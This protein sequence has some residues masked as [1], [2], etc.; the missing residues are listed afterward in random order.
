M[1][2]FLEEI[3]ENL[4]ER[5]SN[6]LGDVTIVFPNKRAGLFFNKA[7][8]ER[9]K[10]PLWSPEIQS[11]EEFIYSL[12]GKKPADRLTLILILYKAYQKTTGASETFDRFYFWGE[13]MLNDFNDIDR[14]LVDPGNIFPVI[15]NLKEIDATFPF[16]TDEQKKF[17]GNFWGSI[18]GEPADHKEGFLRFWRMLPQIYKTY[19]EMLDEKG[20]CYPGEI[21][22]Q[23][24]NRIK[25]D[26]LRWEG[27][28][29]VFVGFNAL[30]AAEELIIKWFISNE[31]AMIFWDTDSWYL[32]NAW[33]EAGTFHRDYLKDKVLGNTFPK[34]LP[35]SLA[36][37][38][39]SIEIVS[40][41]SA[42]S[43]AQWTAH[44]IRELKDKGM[45]EHPE[46]T[47][48]VLPDE[49]MI[50]TLLF[51]LPP[52]AGSVNITVAYPVKIV[53]LFSFFELVLEL[54]ENERSSSNGTWYSHVQALPLLSHPVVMEQMGET[55][56]AIASE[57]RDL[58][59]IYIP[60]GKL[61]AGGLLSEIFK[62]V[63]NPGGIM[64]YLTELL[65]STVTPELP[66]GY[67]HEFHYYFFKLFNRINV[68]FS[69]EN[70]E[71]TFT[72]LKKLFRQFS[73][74]ERIS[75]SGEPLQGL[76][77]MGILETRNLD[78]DNVII[79]DANEGVLPG[80]A[81]H[82]SFIPYNVRRAFR[83]PN[84]EHDGSILAYLFYRLLQRSENVWIVYNTEEAGQSKGEPSRFIQQL[85]FD[86]G[87]KIKERVLVQHLGVRTEPE[88]EIK[89]SPEVNN[90]LRR[91]LSAPG[92]EEKHL[93]PSAI[94]TWLDCPVSFYF[95]YILGAR[96]LQEVNP[97]FDSLLFG[98]ILHKAMEELYSPYVGENEGWITPE[99]IAR[100]R[101]RTGESVRQ[102]F[103]VHF[104]LRDSR[105]FHF[106]GRNILGRELII[107]MINRILAIDEKLVPFRILG[108]EVPINYQVPVTL[109]DGNYRLN[110]RGIIDR[111][112]EKDGQVRIIDYKSG[113]DSGRFESVDALFGVNDK[114]RNKAVFQTLFYSLVLAEQGTYP[115]PVIPCLYNVREIF[116]EDFNPVIRIGAGGGIKQTDSQQ[117]ASEILPAF[118][119]NLNSLLQEI[120]DPDIPFRHREE[121]SPCNICARAGFPI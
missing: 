20:Y 104:G 52:E 116:N 55:A 46:K 6:D 21:Y 98:N 110:V 70:T 86:P 35:S 57:I 71:I 54:H 56:N 34:R 111:I 92:N 62:P 30:N 32:D 27:K 65:V 75:F 74:M 108:T 95:K 103:T 99:I 51:A 73:R 40:T 112:E 58:N 33:H 69:G 102:S 79:L 88:L 8:S 68:T 114:K 67:G 31:K 45:L 41:S 36:G 117:L 90:H 91:Y 76:Q 97:D 63:G 4:L 81:G 72:L 5:F 16:L 64:D 78:F 59:S 61:S 29:L 38:K 9:V 37:T 42:S 121:E 53:S 24:A 113:R 94:T 44:K 1:K 115:G 100:L 2:Y 39:Q 109:K 120:F 48:I 25:N 47:V 23:V 11:I 101:E 87:F 3:A 19:N 93:S 7:L 82:N 13:M 66:D 84:F 118:Q 17:I 80:A 22:L 12:H 107:L 49:S 60:A 14:Y 18:A 83:L 106:H 85:K 10:K 43:Q 96:E 50:T 15:K 119:N 26:K 89:K 28:Q 77:I 105:D